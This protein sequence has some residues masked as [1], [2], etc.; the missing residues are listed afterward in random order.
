VAKFIVADPHFGHHGVCKFLAP[1]GVSKL[2]P[3]DNIEDMDKELIHRWNSVVRPDDEVYVL[4]DV[5]MN[6]KHLPTVGLCNGRKHLIKGNHDVFKLAEYQPYFYEISACRTLN[7]MILTHIPIHPNQLGR[8]E[9]N[10]HGHLHA[11]EVMQDNGQIDP[12][13]T[14]VSM[15]HLDYFPITMEQLRVKIALR[16]LKYPVRAK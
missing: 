6:R 3:W 16:K 14:C 8:F 2:R 15:E 12:R 9:Q 11:F 5:V 7:D 10:V 13:Y 1:D 4:G